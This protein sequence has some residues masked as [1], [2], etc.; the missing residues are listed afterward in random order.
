MTNPFAW[1]DE[2]ISLTTQNITHMLR[3]Y[4]SC[5]AL[6]FVIFSY[7]FHG[8][9]Q[10]IWETVLDHIRDISYQ[11]SPI[12]LICDQEEW[13]TRMSG[14]GREVSRIQRALD[15]RPL[16]DSLPYPRIDTTRLTV[17]QTVSRILEI[18]RG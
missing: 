12:T 15:T 16:Y 7:G 6:D 4:L 9:R 2:L 18:V 13:I 3:S 14:D 11:F 17:Q 1:N 8:P 10:Q 5:N